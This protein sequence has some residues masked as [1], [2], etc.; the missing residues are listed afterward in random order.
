VAPAPY[1]PLDVT[2]PAGKPHYGVGGFHEFTPRD[3]SLGAAAALTL[4]YTDD[5]VV[6]VDEQQLRI[7]RWNDE[8]GDW[9]LVGGEVHADLNTVTASV[10]QLGNFTLA[11]PMPAG[12]LVWAVAALTQVGSGPDVKT[13]ARLRTEPLRRND[14]QPV[15]PGTLVH[16]SLQPDLTLEEPVGGIGRILTADARGDIEGTQVLVGADGRVEI[17][18][19]LTG[20]PDS[21]RVLSFADVGTAGSDA[22]VVLVQP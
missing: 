22:I 3:V 10:I 21:V 6:G 15:A 9:S 18:V 16:V 20:A 13:V 11:P 1:A 17:E 12:P 8:L 4:A 14:G 2:G 19:E 5:E 7:Y